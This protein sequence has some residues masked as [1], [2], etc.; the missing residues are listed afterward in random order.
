MNIL[1]TVVVAGLLTAA[2]G[3]GFIVTN[4]ELQA[5]YESE[6]VPDE[7]Y[8]SE[9]SA[10]PAT[11]DSVLSYDTVDF[12]QAS[13]SLPIDLG[14]GGTEIKAHPWIEC[15]V[16]ILGSRRV[17]LRWEWIYIGGTDSSERVRKCREW[18]T[19]YYTETKYYRTTHDH[20]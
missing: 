9:C 18:G 15:V 14:E 6:T 8:S 7:R 17:C 19:R 4:P 12:S 10:L 2:T 3:L 11:K 5:N 1:K 16:R 13:F 20:V